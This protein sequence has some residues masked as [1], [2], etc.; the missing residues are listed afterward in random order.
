[1]SRSHEICIEA[2]RAVIVFVANSLRQ[3][4]IFT[5]HETYYRGYK[6]EVVEWLGE[7]WEDLH[8]KRPKWFTEKLI[9]SIP[10]DYIPHA[11]GVIEGNGG[12][13]RGRENGE[14][15]AHGENIDSMIRHK[16]HR[17]S[18]LGQIGGFLRTTLDVHR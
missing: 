13:G 17:E 6:E 4:Q 10:G 15:H 5:E 8:T 9:R 1:M 7:V 3:Q 16:T 14:Y 12:G 2:K 11:E 18:T